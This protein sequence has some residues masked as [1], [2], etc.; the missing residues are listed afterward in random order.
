MGKQKGE[1]YF[2]SEYITIKKIEGGELI[3]YDRQS[4]YL[5]QDGLKYGT[6]FNNWDAPLGSYSSGWKKFRQNLMR[7]KKL[8][9]RR[10]YELAL[11][12]DIVAL[13]S[14]GKLDLTGKKVRIIDG[15]KED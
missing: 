13:S 3:F 4:I 10:C 15:A 6:V 9:V 2:K 14:Y 1:R 5:Y 11:R 7:S 12:Y 8:T